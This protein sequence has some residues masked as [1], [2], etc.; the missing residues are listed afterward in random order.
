MAAHIRRREFIG[1]LGSA[2]SAWPL[3]ARAQVPKKVPRLCFIT[4]DPA[5]LRA[6]QFEAFF[7]V[8]S[9]LGYA[10]ERPLPSTTFPRLHR[11][12]GPGGNTARLLAGGCGVPGGNPPAR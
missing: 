2:A 3:A 8:L 10:D 9:D 12:L 6:N 1:A 11:V 7:Q 5:T 4:F